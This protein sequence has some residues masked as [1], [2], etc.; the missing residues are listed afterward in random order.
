MYNQFG[1]KTSLIEQKRSEGRRNDND[2]GNP[3]VVSDEDFTDSAALSF[4]S[5]FN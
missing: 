2:N 4:F 1:K 5:L 3:L